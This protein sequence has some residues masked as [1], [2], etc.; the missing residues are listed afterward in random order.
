DIAVLAVREG[1]SKQRRVPLAFRSVD[2]NRDIDAL[3]DRDLSTSWT[4]SKGG[5][6]LVATF[7]GPT[8]LN[9]IRIDLK[10]L[11]V[12][13]DFRG[14]IAISKKG[15]QYESLATFAFPNHSDTTGSFVIPFEAVST[16]KIRISLTGTRDT[17][18]VAEVEFRLLHSPANWHQKIVSTKFPVTETV[19][20]NKD[21][22]VMFNDEG[23]MVKD[24]PRSF[25][26]G[27]GVLKWPPSDGVWTIL[28]FGYTAT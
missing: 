2:N 10:F 19:A 13:T 26:R 11:S 21:R 1:G 15:H 20:A 6:T 23:L 24:V 18:Q 17:I 22:K 4:S 14:S 27:L 8:T 7:D 25:D 28:R 3:S 12:G 16:R 9:G 5:D